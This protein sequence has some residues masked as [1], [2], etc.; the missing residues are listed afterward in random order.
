MLPNSIVQFS[1][2]EARRYDAL[3]GQSLPFLSS[4]KTTTLEVSSGILLITRLFRSLS[5][6][7]AARSFTVIT[8]QAF[9]QRSKMHRRSAI[10][11]VKCVR[12][13]PRYPT[14]FTFKSDRAAVSKFQP[15]NPL[16]PA[17]LHSPMSDSDPRIHSGYASD[18]DGPA[19]T[20]VPPPTGGTKPFYSTVVAYLTGLLGHKKVD[21]KKSVAP[22][23]SPK[24]VK[25]FTSL[26]TSR[27]GFGSAT[28][29]DDRQN[30]FRDGMKYMTAP[31]KDRKKLNEA[32]VALLHNPRRPR[33]T[34]FLADRTQADGE[35][36][37]FARRSERLVSASLPESDQ[38]FDDLLRGAQ[39]ADHPNGINA[40]CVALAA[41]ISLSLVRVNKKRPEYNETSPTLDLSPLYGVTDSE[42]DMVRSKD[43]RGM[44]SP[45][46]FYD[47]RVT[48]LPPAVSALLILWNRNHNFIA[49]QLLLNNEG[50]KW[51]DPSE[52]DT[53]E[54]T[55]S[56]R[57]AAQDD[58]IFQIA[59]SINCIQF[60]NVVVE[61]FLKVV[62]GLSNVGPGPNL[63][64]LLDLKQAEKGKGHDSAVEF[65]LMYT[66]W[67]SMASEQDVEAFETAVN[68]A[69]IVS[70]VQDVTSPIS[71]IGAQTFQDMLHGVMSRN[72]NRR[73]RNFARI[74]RGSDAR[75]KDEDLAGVLHDAT[76][77]IAG[78]AR[79]RGTHPCFRPAE[80]A[81]IEQ[82]RTWKVG[83][84]NE[85]RKFLGLRPLKSFDD[86]NSDPEI[87]NAAERLYGNIDSLELYPGL[88][89]E[90][91]IKTSG[92]S[93]G[94]TLTY[95]LL[96]DLVTVIRSDPRFTTD[97]T[98]AKLTHWGF[99]DCTVAPN[100][101]AY[102][103]WLPKLLQRNLPRNY[104][105]DNVYGLFPLTR[106]S[107]AESLLRS[108]HQPLLPGITYSFERPKV[109]TVRTI[110][111]TTAI[112][113]VF[114]NPDVYTTIY[115]DDLKALSNG[116][117]FFLGFDDEK[118]HDRDLMMTLFAL[119]PDKGALS[120]YGS[121]F[122]KTATALIQ[123][124]STRTNGHVSIDVVRDVIN[125]TCT[126]WV[127]T[128]LCGLSVKEDD[129]VTTRHDEFAAL[130]GYVFR[131]IDPVSGWATRIRALQTAEMLS[132]Q[133]KK[134]LPIPK[135]KAK[136]T[137]RDTLESTW[138]DILAYVDRILAEMSKDGKILPQHS[139][140]TFLD[141]II[142][143]NRTQA[144][145][146]GE[147]TKEGHLAQ[148]VKIQD[149]DVPNKIAVR[150]EELEE[151]RVLATIIGLAVV[152]S[153]KYANACTQAVDF[154]LDDSRIK[155]R[156]EI[157]RLSTLPPAD[158]RTENANAKI[159]GYIREAQRLG[160]NLGVWRNIVK[161][162]V[163]PQGHGL[164]PISV[165]AG[166]RI[167]ASFSK[168]HTNPQDFEH[169]FDIDPNRKTPSIQG[170]G[171]HKCPGISFVDQTM[172]ELFKAIFRLK[173]LRRDPGRAGRLE[174][175]VCHPAPL[176]TD[177][178][179]YL[180]STGEM[181]HFPRSLSLIYDDDGS[182]GGSSPLPKKRKWFIIFGDKT[183]HL[184]KLMDRAILV[185]I[186]S[187][188][189][190]EFFYTIILLVSHIRFSLP[191][192]PARSTR[193]VIKD[194]DI[195]RVAV[196]CPTP[197]K[198]LH[199]YE[200]MAFLP[201]ADGVHPDPVEYNL[202]STKPHKLSIM[203]IDNRDLRMGV[204]V[205]N[206]L[207]GMTSR[208]VRNSS[209]TCGEKFSE[210]LAKKFSSGVVVVPSG[211][212]PVR[213]EWAGNGFVSNATDA[214]VDM[215]LDWV[216]HPKRRFLW[217]RELCA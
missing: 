11:S 107:V 169:S 4:S 19:E 211:N 115:G 204:Y 32:A 74:R 187:F 189:L 173:N 182:S 73:Q 202:N 33:P 10:E 20:G 124:K 208:I 130:Y 200:I 190:F 143:A 14:H 71:D 12:P 103:T 146:L 203:A 121:Y 72:P 17:A 63:D 42:S 29:I 167:Y 53:A 47:D 141:R 156:K 160:Q 82:A 101:G 59:R 157:I 140:L 65:S 2:H 26:G 216:A 132:K 98:P 81:L 120:R 183:A 45:D 129:D 84:L 144:F 68:S 62:A 96:V 175:I 152:T 16:P 214:E 22:P 186:V 134:G 39:H 77:Q 90:E 64:V 201:G 112:S 60:K 31:S 179:V 105:Y 56:P 30:T 181:S 118:L 34:A 7:R 198:L 151:R 52:Q 88:H 1:I 213:I 193:P 176:N 172:P 184:R 127:C 113:H 188:L 171:L 9:A 161:D 126:R 36:Y 18:N 174:Q 195:K 162:D 97:L 94:Y 123:E 23:V 128:T 67:S 207:R 159:A 93:L 168:A 48:F 15:Y 51:V 92:L 192:R 13:H 35:R 80:V 194:T 117:G 164:P 108:Q 122:G 199:S 197:T 54:G 57:L 111:T 154:Y 138:K 79:G 55:L 43:G 5:A 58:E 100:N 148:L 66:Y 119:I 99:R 28:E 206:E 150:E 86:W 147:L 191:R 89:A 209:E 137:L 87:A 83:T 165:R 69:R 145:R 133:I 75:F 210:C 104:P 116:Y 180:D 78:A 6:N 27:L 155:E 217:R 185:L 21:D 44:L 178:K 212:H 46:C 61:D 91:T 95:A 37:P 40:L 102:G 114:N 149:N 106:P 8:L 131:N 166:E 139:A 109:Q 205:D 70:D 153:V 196:A 49:R 38:V 163:I 136:P 25:S 3:L 125:A 142:K 177:P 85:F 170:M 50:K 76:E 41:V 110:E 215:E 158:A 135:N 24:I